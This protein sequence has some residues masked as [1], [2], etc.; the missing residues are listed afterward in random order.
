VLQAIQRR[1]MI[2]ATIANGAIVTSRYS[3]ML[4]RWAVVEAPKKT[5]VASATVI[6][7]SVP[8]AMTWFQIIAVRPDSSAPSDL[9]ALITFAGHVAGDLVACGDDGPGHR[10]LRWRRR[11]LRRRVVPGG[12]CT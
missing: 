1:A 5:V 8:L 6:M 10:V 12:T 7:A 2:G 3:R 11:Q 4:P 9:L